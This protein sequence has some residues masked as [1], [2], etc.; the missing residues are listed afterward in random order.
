VVAG[1]GFVA[2]LTPASAP[3]RWRRT[4]RGGD[5]AVRVPPTSRDEVGELTAA[6]NE[7]GESLQQKAR[8]QQAF[9][10]YASDYVL[11]TLLESPEGSELQGVERD[12]TVLFA[13]IRGFTRLSEGLEPADVVALLNDVFQ[14]V[15]DCIL[16]RGGTL[17]KF[18]GDSVMAYFGARCRARIM[19]P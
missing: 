1:L 9:G 3:A 16:R 15:S 6:F 12:V 2:L 18:I 4:P 8:I 11:Q 19:R 13:D 10:R 17:D 5:L 14:L 7:M